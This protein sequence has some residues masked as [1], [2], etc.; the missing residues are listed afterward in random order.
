MK[1]QR[2]AVIQGL[3]K[4]AVYGCYSQVH[5]PLVAFFNCGLLGQLASG[6]DD[7]LVQVGGETIVLSQHPLVSFHF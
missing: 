2:L 7:D 6:G 4:T 3:F 1:L 5:S